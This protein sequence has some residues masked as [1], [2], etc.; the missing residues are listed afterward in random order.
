MNFVLVRRRDTTEAAGL[1]VL[2]YVRTDRIRDV[3]VAMNAV[4]MPVLLPH[5][6]LKVPDTGIKNI[7]ITN[8][9]KPILGTPV[10]E[11]C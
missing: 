7:K 2:R 8:T 4:A 10:S 9:K 5:P 1:D 6:P 11:A 3:C